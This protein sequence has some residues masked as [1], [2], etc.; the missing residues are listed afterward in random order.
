VDIATLH[1]RTIIIDAH[2]DALLDVVA[3]RRSLLE[4]SD[5]GQADLPRLQE[6]GVTAQVFALFVPDPYVTH[7]ATQYALRALDHLYAAMEQSD[8][9]L[10]LARTATDIE[11]A[12]TANHVAAIIGMEGAEPLDGSLEL[13]RIFHRLGL[14]IL[15]LTWNRRNA[16][17]DGL[18][19]ERT[20]GGLTPFGVALVEECNR[21]GIVIDVAHLSPKGVQDVL[22]TSS[23]PVIASHANARALCDHR[24]N[25]T[26]EQMRAIAAG[27]GVIGA[28]FVPIFITKEPADATVERLLDH[29]A[30]MIQVVGPE[31]VAL[32]SDF[33]GIGSPP[34]GLKSISDLPHVTEG[35][36]ARGYPLED[37]QRILGGNWL[38]V[39][40]Q[41]WR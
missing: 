18:D 2:C 31:H 19:F 41:V 21:L 17:A 30:H 4:R 16:A 33:D 24:R 34:P 13:L 15:G 26:D 32:G 35:L 28:T 5:Q 37:V 25:L 40:R 38:R 11:A 7:A 23:Q 1:R 6:A 29:V 36:L 9:R 8:G 20:G 27:G 39:F 12:H 14:R 3:G 10:A 22:E